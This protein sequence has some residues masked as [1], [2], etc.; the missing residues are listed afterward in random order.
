MSAKG[1]RPWWVYALAFVGLAICLWNGWSDFTPWVP[2]EVVQG[3]VRDAIRQGAQLF[4]QFIAP[5]L[6]VA[7]L[8]SEGAA[9]V[10]S[11]RKP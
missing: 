10:G 7:F 1:L 2:Q 6:L 4:V 5:A 3:M 9:A 11:R 8:V